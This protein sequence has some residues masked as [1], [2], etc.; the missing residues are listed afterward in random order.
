MYNF[1]YGFMYKTL[2]GFLYKTLHGTLYG[3]LYKTLC[4][5]LYETLCKF[6]YKFMYKCLG[7]APGPRRQ[8][9]LGQDWDQGL[10]RP[11]PRAQPFPLR[12]STW[13]GC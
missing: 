6:I 10:A 9:E 1:M 8:W 12:P 2:Y 7:S 3:T 13:A 5:T 11:G 4:R